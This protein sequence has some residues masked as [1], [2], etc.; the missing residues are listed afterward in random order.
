MTTSEDD[1]GAQLLSAVA[2]VNR[3]ATKHSV[4]PIPSGQARLLSLVDQYGT[5]RVGELAAADHC[6]QPTM[7]A[8][9]KRLEEQGYL[10]RTE[11]EN[12]GRASLISLTD[13]GR[14]AL[15]Q[16]RVARSA[17]ITPVLN[18]LSD[19]DRRTL[20]RANQ[21]LRQIAGKD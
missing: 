12:D 5:A 16:V 10:Q 4:M 11:D 9:V 1:L 15:A 21:L 8:Q 17:T 14:G 19:E 20:V 13:T 3:W 6:S 7:T 2:K 18:Q